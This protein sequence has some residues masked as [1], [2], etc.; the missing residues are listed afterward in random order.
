MRADKSQDLACIEAIIQ[1][2]DQ[3]LAK[4][5]SRYGQVLLGYLTHL[6]S[7]RSVAEELVQ[8]VF[9]IVWR[10]AWRFRAQST[11]RTWLFGI[12]HN[13]GL[14]HIRRKRPETMDSATTE[15][16]ISPELDPM[17][18]ADLALKHQRLTSALASLPPLQR[19]V[20]ELTFYHGLARVEVAR[21]LDCPVGTVKSRLHYA[22]KA[23]A[24]AL[25]TEGEE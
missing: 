20:I 19:A 7:D 17:D 12:A 23:L 2:D 15:G 22:L 9:L 11:V 4:L 1:G 8:E 13:L 6:I 18:L 21:V 10:D 24:H 16:L 14:M 3:A 25:R 5:Y